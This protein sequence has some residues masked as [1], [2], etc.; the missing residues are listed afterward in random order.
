MSKVYNALELFKKYAKQDIHDLN[1]PRIFHM[2]RAY[3]RYKTGRAPF[4]MMIE[5]SNLCNFNC[6]T[7]PT[8]RKLI[9]RPRK[10]MSFEIFKKII[11]NSK[12]VVHNILLHWTNEPLT[13]PEIDRFVSYC[14]KNNL[15]T[16]FSTNA[17][18]LNEN[19]ARK[20]LNAKLDKITICLDGMSKKTFKDF[21]GQ[22]KF[23]TVVKNIKKFMQLKK[24]LNA[25][26]FVEIQFIAN[27][28]NQNEIEKIKKFSKEN[29]ID[30]LFI[31][32]FG[33]CGYFYTPKERAYLLNKFVPTRKDVAK[34]FSEKD[35]SLLVENTRKCEAPKTTI[36]VTVE[37]DIAICCYDFTG[38]FLYGNLVRE[39]LKDILNSKKA[40]GIISQGIKRKLGVCKNCPYMGQ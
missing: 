22:D 21:R 16:D 33:L 40:R 34:R 10:S 7:C 14:R 13:N 19:A 17:V 23:E 12:D 37:G 36:C 35:C 6:E 1:F 15:F 8:P 5:T 25:K 11:D 4:T 28:F 31:K 29:K 2:A 26:T 20:I 24:E 9:N 39:K 38:K 30:K 18:L 27:R 32:T 3:L